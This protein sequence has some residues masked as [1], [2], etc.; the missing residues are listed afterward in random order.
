MVTAIMSMG[1]ISIDMMLPAFPEMRAEFGMAPGSPQIAWIMTAFF[2]G[3][4]VGPWFFGPPSDRY[5][6]KP[7]L[8]I[9]IGLYVLAALASIL[10]P[11]F[12]YLVATR[13]LWGLAAGA[14]RALAIAMVRDRYAGEQMARLM[15]LIMTVFILVP[16]LAPGVGAALLHI[17]PWRIVF[18]VPVVFALLLAVWARRLP[19]TLSLERRRPFTRAALLEATKAVVTT[20]EAVWFGLAVGCLFGVMTAYL[21]N[22]ELILED[23]YGYGAWFPFFFG[24]IAIMLGLGSLTSARF[25]LH[26]GLHRWITRISMVSL[27]VSAAFLTLV[28]VT[29][30]KP[31]FW[32]LFAGL[33]ALMPCVTC[34]VPNCN[35]AAMTPLPHIAGTASA[36][37]GTVSS[38]GGALIGG[39]ISGRFD[40]TV[41]PF[42]IGTSICVLLAAL[43]IAV[44]TGRWPASATNLVHRWAPRDRR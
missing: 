42:A 26:V 20:R 24:A 39:A 1:A 8:N 32:F 10:A 4:S 22:S 30:G 6:R 21:S 28:L 15:S 13:F 44:A 11:S 41:R 18:W 5:G 27:A 17:A 19:E 23:V 7:L 35:T 12:G 29:G 43:F 38:A 34:L 16:I 40:G 37:I 33:C 36:I 3:L 25:V 9:G 2:L 14:P 31:P